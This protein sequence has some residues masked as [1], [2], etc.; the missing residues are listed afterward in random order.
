MYRIALLLALSCTIVAN[1]QDAAT[2]QPIQPA[3]ITATRPPAWKLG[4][5]GTDSW[6][7]PA[8]V[9]PCSC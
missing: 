4:W 1:G 3:P 2:S 7:F 9:P 8:L 6:P 5:A